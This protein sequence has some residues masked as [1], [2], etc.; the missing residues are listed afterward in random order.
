[1]K[2]FFRFLAYLYDWLI[3]V[4]ILWTL[5]VLTALVTTVMA[6]FVRNPEI[7]N[8]PAQIW[9]RIVCYGFLTKVSVEGRENIQEKKSYV[10]VANHQSWFDIWIIYGWLNRPF[11]W[12]MKKELRKIPFVGKAC[13]SVGHIFMDRS[14]SI[15]AKKCLEKA[16]KRLEKDNIS[17]VVFPEGTRTKDG[18]VGIFKRGAF[19]IASDLKLPVVPITIEGA[20]ERMPRNKFRVTPGRMRMKIHPPIEID[21]ELNDKEMRELAN[22]ARETVIGGLFQNKI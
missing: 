15:A 19:S 2:S 10:F 14:N 13:E 7:I 21:H 22:K 8:K 16:A 6:P 4:P 11:C 20:F 12:V 5:T 1:M 3:A 17:V 9:S 18:T